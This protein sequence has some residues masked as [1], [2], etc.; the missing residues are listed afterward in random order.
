MMHL[1]K[2]K[3]AQGMVEFALLAPLLLL[4]LV[5]TM[6]F[7]RIIIIYTSITNAVREGARYGVVV[8]NETEIRQVVS[9]RILLVPPND[10]TVTVACD[11]GPGSTE[12]SFS[13]ANCY[14]GG[15]VIVRANYA[16]QA[17]TP[18]IQ[19]FLGGGINVSPD[20]I[21]TIASSRTSGGAPA[22]TVTPDGSATDTPDADATGTASAD[23]TATSAA[24]SATPT[25]TPEPG[26]TNTQTNTPTPEPLA[27]IIIDDPV[28]EGETWVTGTAEGNQAVT[29]RIIQTGLLRTVAVDGSGNFSFTGLPVLVVGHTVLVQGYG[30][31]DLEIVAPLPTP[32][33]T[34]EVTENA[35][36]ADA[37][38]SDNE[39][40]SVTI[41]GMGWPSNASAV[42]DIRF[43]LIPEVGA[44][45][46]IDEIS[47]G[48]GGGFTHLLVIPSLPEGTNQIQALGVKNGSPVPGYES[49]LLDFLRPCPATPTPTLTPSPTPIT[50]PDLIVSGVVLKDPGPYG[51]YEQ[52]NVTVGISNI[53]ERDVSTLHWVDLYA[54]PSGGDLT[55]EV[56][57]DYVAVNALGAGSTISFTMFVID[58]FDTTGQHTLQVMVDTWDQI[59]ESEE[60]NNVSA[61]LTFTITVANLE[62]TPTNTPE[63]T[64]GPRGAISGMTYL[65]ET[66]LEIG[67]VAVYVYDDEGRLWGSGRSDTNGYYIIENIPAGEY[68][69]VGQLRLAEN[70][71]IGQVF[72]V[73]V[74]TGTTTYGVDIELIE[75]E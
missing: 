6:E 73:T 50:E 19:P 47:F 33:P 14:V 58:G 35:I 54:D 9:E 28:T 42:K 41:T 24:L 70:Q 64:P 72:P 3:R 36:S 10:V 68:T 1:K 45:V 11:S 13:D 56:S 63:I 65:F 5:G 43:M 38:C 8:Q 2:S 67:N 69:V 51:T 60:G 25:D 44:P 12:H 31:Q 75:V 55:Q 66:G 57:A 26:A 52:I 27:P 46:Q 71:Y 4:I 39:S 23:L 37:T 20:G 74:S 21:R 15:R 34:V 53:G 61:S 30:Q 16:I 62:P 18:L 7:G 49:N 22:P 48:G 32:T 29:L 40:T 17:M 59:E